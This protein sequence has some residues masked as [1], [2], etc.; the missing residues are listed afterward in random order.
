MR[1]LPEAF[2]VVVPEQQAPAAALRLGVGGEEA[3]AAAAMAAQVGVTR[4]HVGWRGAPCLLLSVCPEERRKSCMHHTVHCAVGR[5][6]WPCPLLPA[7]LTGPAPP[8]PL[9]ATRG[10]TPAARW[11]PLCSW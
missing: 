11:T 4:H 2:S 6:R 5:R 7:D 1:L 8:V 9:R 3:A 10:V